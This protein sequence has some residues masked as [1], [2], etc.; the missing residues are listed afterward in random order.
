MSSSSSS[1][2]LP[3]L[4]FSLPRALALSFPSIDKE[5]R[6]GGEGGRRR[7]VGRE[8]RRTEEASNLAG[9]RKWGR[10]C[11]VFRGPWGNKETGTLDLNSRES[12][13]PWL[14]PLCCHGGQC[15]L[16]CLW[17]GDRPQHAVAPA[18]EAERPTQWNSGWVFSLTTSP[19]GHPPWGSVHP[20]SHYYPH[21]TTQKGPKL[22]SARATLK[23]T[24]TQPDD[25]MDGCHQPL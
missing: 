19:L 3:S 2:S 6:G 9:C 8:E 24:R 10:L 21:L 23:A 22:V 16:S 5:E 25:K 17:S 7:G 12:W 11:V 20:W 18:S 4:P 15:L 14:P 13:F 1:S